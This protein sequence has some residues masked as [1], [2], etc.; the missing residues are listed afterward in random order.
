MSEQLAILLIEDN[1]EDIDQLASYIHKLESK[2][3]ELKLKNAHTL[4]EALRLMIDNIFDIII[5][6]LYLP[7]SQGIDSFLEIQKKYC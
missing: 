2:G 5:A 3:L 7:D 1:V 6:N 4:E